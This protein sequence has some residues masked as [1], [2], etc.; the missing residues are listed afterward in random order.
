M[1]KRQRKKLRKEG[2]RQ[3]TSSRNKPKHVPY[4][5]K[6][7]KIPDQV[8]PPVLAKG[9]AGGSGAGGS[10]AG[11]DGGKSPTGSAMKKETTVYI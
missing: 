6:Y 7:R 8:L 4:S 9:S 5:Q 1:P 3:R 11:G 2:L 10:G